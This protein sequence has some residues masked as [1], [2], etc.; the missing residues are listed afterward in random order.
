MK[1]Q[2][3]IFVFGSNRQG[4][5]GKGSALTARQKYGAIYGQAEGLQG[6]SYAIV[7]KEL[8]TDYAPVSLTEVANGVVRFLAFAAFKPNYKFIVVAIG[9]SLAGFKPEQIAP[10][11]RNSPPNVELPAEFV[12]V[13]KPKQYVT[14]ATNQVLVKE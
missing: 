1:Y 12:Q 8:R 14:K 5:H 3:T 6:S 7:T 13:L 9:C 2:R 10:L 4:R 11:F